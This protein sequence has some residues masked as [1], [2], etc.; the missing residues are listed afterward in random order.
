M[1]A[2][3]LELLDDGQQVADGPCEAIQPDH[4]Q[5]LAGTDVAQKAGQDRTT[6]VGAGAMLLEDR[7]AAGRARLIELRIGALF[8]G[9]DPRVADQA[10]SCGGFPGFWLHKVRI[11]RR[12]RQ[13]ILQIN[14]VHVNGR[15]QGWQGNRAKEVRDKSL[16]C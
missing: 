6:T 10:A 12:F 8:L 5:G 11:A 4:D 9:G 15:L 14:D 1:R 7:I 2:A 13:A 3:R 16:E